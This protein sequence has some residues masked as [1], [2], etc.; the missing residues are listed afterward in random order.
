MG[1][2]SAY[3]ITVTATSSGGLSAS[4]QY[5]VSV[6]SAAVV[7]G[8]L[9]D[10]EILLS[11]TTTLTFNIIDGDSSNLSGVQVAAVISDISVIPTSGFVINP[12]AV[13]NGPTTIDITPLKL[14]SADITLSI[15]DAD[16][17][18][19][20]E[21]FKL[22]V[23]NELTTTTPSS[24]GSSGG[25]GSLGGMLVLLLLPLFLRRKLKA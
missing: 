6:I 19:V 17:H 8:G 14:G 7:S 5:N 1:S 24:S 18:V 21:Q 13:L 4:S 15:T 9:S 25:G 3:T 12:P 20:T 16:G 2:F 10:R 11:E 23:A 22:T